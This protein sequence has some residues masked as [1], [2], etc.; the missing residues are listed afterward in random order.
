MNTSFLSASLLEKLMERK[1]KTNSDAIWSFFFFRQTLANKFIKHLL[2]LFIIYK[3]I[4]LGKVLH[5]YSS[6]KLVSIL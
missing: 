2:S 3:I 6:Q 1:L 4:S 5:F